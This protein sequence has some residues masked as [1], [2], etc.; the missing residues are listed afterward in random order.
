MSKENIKVKVFR[1]NPAK[2][3]EPRFQTYEV[4]RLS[5]EEAMTKATIMN[6]LHSQTVLDVLDHIFQNIDPTLS[7]YCSCRRGECGA[8]GAVVNGETVRSCVTLAK[9][10][11]TIEPL[12]HLQVVKDLVVKEYSAR[13]LFSLARTNTLNLLKKAYKFT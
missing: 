8:C 10:E 7:Y 6:E 9:D 12:Q 11:M 13:E 4:P 3:K 1:F 2:D 5:D